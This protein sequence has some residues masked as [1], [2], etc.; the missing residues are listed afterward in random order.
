ME[1]CAHVESER[2]RERRVP[3]RMV[4]TNEPLD[5]VNTV[6]TR[7]ATVWPATRGDTDGANWSRPAG[8][9]V[10]CSAPP[11]WA[12]TKPSAATAQAVT[13]VA[14]TPRVRAWFDRTSAFR[15]VAS[16]P[17]VCVVYDTGPSQVTSSPLLSIVPRDR[18]PPP[19]GW[20]AEVH[21]GVSLPVAE[22]LRHR[23]RATPCRAPSTRAPRPRRHASR[24]A[25]WHTTGTPRWPRSRRMRRP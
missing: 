7:P 9:G 3:T 21:V 18:E 20:R 23:W 1:M 5:A 2:P 16:P 13:I 24:T 22:G 12:I 19:H 14:A 15:V 4:R 11:R 17:V 6:W 25:A 8:G 10:R